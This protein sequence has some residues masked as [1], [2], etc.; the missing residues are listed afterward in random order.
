M[1]TQS[2]VWRS[3]GASIG[4]LWCLRRT[5]SSPNNG[6]SAPVLVPVPV[7][8]PIPVELSPKDHEKQTRK[9]A[10]H[11]YKGF[12]AG[13]F[14]GVTKLTVG[15]PFDTLKVR[16]QTA[17]PSQF[18]GPIDCLKKT[19]KK[20]GVRGLYKG[21]TPPLV[22]W[23]FMDS[24]MLGSMTQYRNLLRHYYYSPVH[25]LPSTSPLTPIG[26]AIAG[27]GSGWTVS[28]IAAP[29]EHIKARLQVQ[30]HD[31]S[32]PYYPGPIAAVKHIGASHGIRGLYH[33]LLSTFFFRSH[34]AGFW[35]TYS[36]L[37]DQL[38]KHTSLSDPAINFWAGGFGAQC[39]WLT[40]YPFD[41]VKQRVMTDRIVRKDGY[42]GGEKYGK[43]RGVGWRGFWRGFAPCFLR[44]FPANA[45][46]LVA[47]EGVM[48]TLP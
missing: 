19:I 14:S 2:L 22:G 28:F 38:K 9:H 30:Y 24:I 18:A 13:V 46:A 11:P 23:M 48:R 35:F 15:H 20:E 36:H 29:V 3:D 4:N 17:P 42:V 6:T 7:P 12:V 40:S 41:V 43:R 27:I 10:P 44:A 16:L 26:N 39:F 33:G 32:Q 34:F 37:T 5:M 25:N 31:A 45:C 21:A 8:A 1:A 47:I